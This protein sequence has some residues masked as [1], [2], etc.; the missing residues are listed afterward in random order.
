MLKGD[1]G[2]DI[3]RKVVS[4]GHEGRVLRRES[5]RK[6][7]ESVL[8]PLVPSTVVAMQLGFLCRVKNVEVSKMRD[9]SVGFVVELGSDLPVRERTSCQKKRAEARAADDDI[10]VGP[11]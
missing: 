3:D 4:R 10:E 8:N 2:Q 5:L 1:P 9:R 11:E 7:G 6:T